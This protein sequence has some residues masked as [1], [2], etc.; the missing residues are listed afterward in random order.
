MKSFKH[1]IEEAGGAEAGSLELV[2][3]NVGKA[4]DFAEKAFARNG[5]DLDKELP[6][7]DN[8]YVKA[9]KIAGTGKTKRKDMPVIVEKDV[10]DLQRRLKG[11]YIDV[12]IPRAKKG[13]PF[14]QGI[15][16]N[17]AKQW[18]E[19]GLKKYDGDADDDKIAVK[20]GKVRIGDLKPIQQQIYFDKSMGQ[21]AEN[22]ADATKKFITSNKTTF[23]ISSDNRI[24]DGHHRYLS[25]VLVDPNMKVNALIIDLPIKTLLP[26]TL[27]YSD[28]V[29]NKR[30][31]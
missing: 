31:Q 6:N 20:K 7:F 15:S 27:S 28:S 23:I 30:N 18:L 22:G 19:N 10:R 5:R 3:T 24:I 12:N 2:K 13:N 1:F 11:G 4:R 17:E 29:G 26:L 16:G 14:P 9:Q 8:A 21:V 25:G